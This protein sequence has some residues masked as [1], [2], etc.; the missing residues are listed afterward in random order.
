MGYEKLEDVP[1]RRELPAA[2]VNLAIAKAKI[3]VGIMRGEQP[4]HG[5]S[6]FTFRSLL[7]L[8][9]IAFAL[10]HF[11]AMLVFHQ[12]LTKHHLERLAVLHH[13]AH[14]K[15]CIEPIAKLTGKTF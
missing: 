1:E 7:E 8:D 15:N 3:G 5:V 2:L 9:R 11:L 13:R 6:T 4:T 12:A 10:V 14:S